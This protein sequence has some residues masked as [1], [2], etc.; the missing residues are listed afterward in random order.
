MKRLALLLSLLWL[1]PLTACQQQ[2]AQP[3]AKP[4]SVGNT[5]EILGAGA[6]FPFPLYSKMFSE[7]NKATQVQVNYQSIG[8]GG[9]VRQILA[10]TVD[11]G[12]S[13][14]FMS[15]EEL[16]GAPGAML[17][18][19][20]V[21]GSVALVYNLPGVTGLRLTPEVLSDLFLGKIRRWD[22]PAL[23]AIN[24]DIKL[25]P[26]D[27]VIVRRSDGSGTTSIFTDYLSKV[28]ATWQNQVG[29]GKS[30]SWPAGLGAKGNEGVAGMITK[31]PGTLGYTELA[32]AMQNNM[33]LAALRNYAGNYVTPSLHS[34]S[35]AAQSPIPNDTRVTLTNPPAPDGYPISGFTWILLYQEQFY[36]TR[37]EEQARGLVKLIW[38]MLHEG[39][40]YAEPL[41]YAPIPPAALTLAE[42][43]LRSMTY[44]GKPIL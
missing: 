8:S 14:A 24:A 19:P 32:Y 26:L 15:D 43:A 33:S 23:K 38:W 37:T 5:A 25:P 9:G 34:T 31:L 20:V 40:Q 36:A 10:R 1:L 13:D 21:L 7:Y 30:V 11:F 44:N 4:S 6:T 3:A 12:A 35:Q 29:S 41:H 39:Q 22:D 27:V 42:K 17:H 18:I 16:Q 28:S 2:E